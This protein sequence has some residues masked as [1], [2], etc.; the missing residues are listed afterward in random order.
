MLYKQALELLH[1][2]AAPIAQP[3]PP[4]VVIPARMHTIAKGDTYDTISSRYGIPR[5]TLMKANPKVKHNRLMPGAKLTIPEIRYQEKFRG[6]SDRVLNGIYMQESHNGRFREGDLDPYTKKPL[7]LGGYQ[8][9][10]VPF[11]RRKAYLKR[12]RGR[13]TTYSTMLDDVNDIYKT[14]YTIADTTDDVKSR[15]IAKLWLTHQAKNYYKS[16]GGVNPSDDVLY[17]KWNGGPN[18]HTNPKTAPY[19][20]NIKLKYR[21]PAKYGLK[22]GVPYKKPVR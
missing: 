6:V 8:I 16:N 3:K 22:P 4:A 15:Q 9:R 1:K 19:A 2:V 17:R 18:G 11:R 12:R 20:A 7:S 10:Q 21:N 5:A 13:P 14:K